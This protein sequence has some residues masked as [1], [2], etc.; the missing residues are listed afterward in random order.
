MRGRQNFDA[1][2]WGSEAETLSREQEEVAMEKVD[3]DSRAM[4]AGPWE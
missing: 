4:G 2:A 3:P 1:Q